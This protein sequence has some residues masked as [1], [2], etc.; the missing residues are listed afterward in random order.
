VIV[1]GYVIGSGV[2]A[3][4]G[5]FSFA[6]LVLDGTPWSTLTYTYFEPNQLHG[7]TIWV[8]LLPALAAVTK[9]GQHSSTPSLS[10]RYRLYYWMGLILA[11]V[12]AAVLSDRLIAYEYLVVGGIVGAVSRW[13]LSRPQPPIGR[14]VRV[15]GLVMLVIGVWSAS[16]YGRTFLPQHGPAAEGDST[17][18][19]ASDVVGDRFVAYVVSNPNNA[20]YAVDSASERTFPFRSVNALFASIGV[21]SPIWLGEAEAAE[22]SR[23]LEEIYR[24]DR[25]TTYS[26]PGYLFLDAGWG[27]IVLF[28]AF[29]AAIGAT[30]QRLRR[31]ALWAFL[32]YPLLFVGVLDS[33]RILY[34]PLTRCVVPAIA[35]VLVAR[36]VRRV[37]PVSR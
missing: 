23:L 28:G 16:E 26:A 24:S 29:G 19:A 12:L 13:N 2:M 4:G 15:I 6:R 3:A 7:F 25:L 20:L 30:F 35:L 27:G 1:G 8:A 37:A 5:P 36:S 11:L 33:F 10:G 9:L 22:P 17:S 32:L 21:D 14:A 18:A 34:W 31:G